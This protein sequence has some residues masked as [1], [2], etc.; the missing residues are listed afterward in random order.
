MGVIGRFNAIV[1]V[2]EALKYIYL[3]G[4]LCSLKHEQLEVSIQLRNSWLHPKQDSSVMRCEVKSGGPMLGVMAAVIVLF[5]V[6][7]FFLSL[8]HGLRA[9]MPAYV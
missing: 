5:L 6:G 4:C 3:H 8:L 1:T 2:Y 7:F 9:C